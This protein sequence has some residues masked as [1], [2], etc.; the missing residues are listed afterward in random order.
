MLTPQLISLLLCLW[1]LPLAQP[2]LALS[3]D[4]PMEIDYEA[5][6]DYDVIVKA[7]ITRIKPIEN[8]LSKTDSMSTFTILE[9]YKGAVSNSFQFL[10]TY[11]T[12]E[13]EFK[14]DSTYLFYGWITQ[15]D[16]LNTHICTYTKVYRSRS[17]LQKELAIVKA[18]KRPNWRYTKFLKARLK[19]LDLLA[20]HCQ[21][22]LD[23]LTH[24]YLSGQLCAEGRIEN[25]R[26]VGFWRFY[27]PNGKLKAE[28]RFNTAGDS[29]GNWAVYEYYLS[30]PYK[31]YVR[32]T[33]FYKNGIQSKTRTN[34]LLQFYDPKYRFP[35]E[36]KLIDK[37][38]PY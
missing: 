26:P 38:F 23:T 12:E 30:P 37:T 4:L 28:G 11:Y 5:Y 22:N 15:G 24:T 20:M 9:N 18:Q 7:Q 16:T 3:C 31:A 27:F 35:K 13:L 21:P 29:I 1:L 10:L 25:Y 2:A 14:M 36:Q 34:T 17:D 6:F 8:R 33:L 19:E 32:T